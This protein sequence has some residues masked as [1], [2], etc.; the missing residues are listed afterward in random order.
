[1]CN[2]GDIRKGMIPREKGISELSLLCLDGKKPLNLN[3]FLALLDITEAE[4]DS[5]I[6]KPMSQ[7]LLDLIYNIEN[8]L[9]VRS[10]L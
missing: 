6:Y 3:E 9:L 1:M 7:K 8:W 2:K 5:L 10:R 4:F